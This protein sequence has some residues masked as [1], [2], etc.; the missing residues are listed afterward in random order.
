MNE[1]VLAYLAVLS[2]FA[3]AS[4]SV[5]LAIMA[6]PSVFTVF[7]AGPKRGTLF[8]NPLLLALV[9]AGIMGAFTMVIPR[10]IKS[11]VR[12]WD[13]LSGHEKSHFISDLLWW[14]LLIPPFL[15]TLILLSAVSVILGMLVGTIVDIPMFFLF[16]SMMDKVHKRYSTTTLDR[17]D[18]R[19]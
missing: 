11:Q 5:V 12:A 6:K 18:S 2:V 17:W 9:A 19:D 3:L 7:S 8:A 10:S 1:R 15:I 4:L 14:G 16:L 13:F